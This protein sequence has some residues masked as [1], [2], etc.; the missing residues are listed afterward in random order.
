MLRRLGN[1]LASSIGKKMVMASTGLL[2]V[3]FL[4]EHLYGNLNLVPPFG[5]ED[6]S[7][8]LEYRDGLHSFGVYLQIAEVGLIALFACHT[9]LAFRLVLENRA[10]RTQKYVVRNDRGAKTVGSASMFFTGALILGYL[11]KHV[12]DFRLNSDYQDAPALTVAKTLSQPFHGAIYVGLA[13]VLGV[14]LSHGFQSAFQSVGLRHPAWSQ[15]IKVGGRAIAGLIA[16]GFASIPLY[17][18]FLW[19]EGGTH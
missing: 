18:L 14:H 5:K 16:V 7:K 17:F 8:F 19:K 1:A 6:G 4:L 9:F 13:M 3:G 11:I 2:L 15:A 10:A 12:L